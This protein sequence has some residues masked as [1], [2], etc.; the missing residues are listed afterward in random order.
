MSCF[1]LLSSLH[2]LEMSPHVDIVVCDIAES[3][4]VAPVVVVI[5]EGCN[6]LLRVIWY[7]V[8]YEV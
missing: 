3:F 6:H 1:R 5:D 8:G 4:V 7:F 2:Y